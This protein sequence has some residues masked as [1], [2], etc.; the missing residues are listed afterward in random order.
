MEKVVMVE[1]N[2]DKCQSQCKN[3]HVCEKDYV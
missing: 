1:W 3:C 2:N